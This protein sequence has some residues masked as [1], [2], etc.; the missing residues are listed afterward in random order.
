MVRALWFPFAELAHAYRPLMQYV[1]SGSPLVLHARNLP[2]APL[3][4]TL[5]PCLFPACTTPTHC[6]PQN[7]PA[8][9]EDGLPEGNQWRYSE[10]ISAVNGGKVERVRF[11]KDGTM[12][13]VRGSVC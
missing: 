8:V 13:Q 3:S 11:S 2:P 12:L 7:A 10:F 6:S 1:W 9:R 5:S 4:L